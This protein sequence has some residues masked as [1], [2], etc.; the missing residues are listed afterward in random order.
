MFSHSD[1]QVFSE[2]PC[3]DEAVDQLVEASIVSFNLQAG[4]LVLV[5]TINKDFKV[6]SAIRLPVEPFNGSEKRYLSDVISDSFSKFPKPHIHGIGDVALSGIVK[7]LNPAIAGA[8][9]IWFVPLKVK[10]S[11]FL[12]I[13]FPKHDC[14]V[15][16]LSNELFT[17]LTQGLF[18]SDALRRAEI[19]E[20]RLKTTELYTKEVGH[21]VASSVQA[22]LAKA[23]SITQKRVEGEAALRRAREIELE[24]M[25]IHRHAESLGIAVDRNYQV[26]EWDDFDAVDVMDDVM[27]HFLSEA[28]E[29]HIALKKECKLN[30]LQLFGDSRAVGHALGQVL[31]N[32]IKYSVGNSTIWVR[33]YD[34]GDYVRFE[35]NNLGIPL[36]VGSE[37]NLIWEF[38]ER[39][40]AA[41]EL[42]VNG[43]GIGLYTTRKIILAHYGTVFADSKGDR[44]ANV[45]IG[46]R[47]QKKRLLQLTHSD[48]VVLGPKRGGQAKGSAL[49]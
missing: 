36:P 18:L 24:I 30:T 1:Y 29:R 33:L 3:S 26:G 7:R 17:K 5:D 49:V 25:A 42:H 48:E 4:L 13:G 32:A 47:M 12:F 2:C 9:R 27:A 35:T 6:V 31:L 10:D 39:S 11:C 22:V 38:G 20:V 34:E 45:T 8:N 15:K 19:A 46:F 40:K 44:V 43:S 16:G 21:D 28:E 14:K 41:K 23:K 37:R